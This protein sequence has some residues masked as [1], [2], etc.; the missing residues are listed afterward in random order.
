MALAVKLSEEIVTKAR[1]ISKA[2]NRSI[3]GQVE[4]WAK[5]G[6]IA[7][8]NPDLT[9]RFIRDILISQQEMDDGKLEPHVFDDE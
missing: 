2:L 1:K 5:I 7:E 6:I 4:H 9:Y 3:A 8:A